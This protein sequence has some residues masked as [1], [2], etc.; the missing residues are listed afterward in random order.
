MQYD[1]SAKTKRQCRLGYRDAAA[2]WRA[3]KGRVYIPV[4]S[5]T[6]RCG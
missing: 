4:K 1:T 5:Y 3:P 6:T 2:P